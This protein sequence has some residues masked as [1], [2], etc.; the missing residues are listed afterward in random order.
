MTVVVPEDPVALEKL[1]PQVAAWEG[2][3]YVRLN[4]NEVP[5]LFDH[6]Y[7]PRIG[8]AV[9][10]RPGKEVTL[11]CTGLMVSRSLDAARELEDS[12]IDARVLEVHTV[13]PIDRERIVQAAEETKAMVTVE[14]HSIIG[15]LGSAVA[16]VTTETH[17]VPIQRVGI[18]DTFAETGPYDALLERYGMATRDIVAAA[19][20][21]VGKKR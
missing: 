13:K 6:S 12:G 5:A 9:V 15:G 14:E 21:A 20:R 11:V 4:R 1:L 16:E 8:E 7:E 17:P 3:V 2:P 18:A 19:Q 10:L